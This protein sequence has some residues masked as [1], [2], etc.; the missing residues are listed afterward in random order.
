MGGVGGKHTG[1]DEA[2]K[3]TR[4]ISPCLGSLKVTIQQDVDRSMSRYNKGSGKADTI[5]DWGPLGPAHCHTS[6]FERHTPTC[7]YCIYISS[8]ELQAATMFD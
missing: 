4:G 1:L 8:G 2:E 6:S 3:P 5:R 7:H